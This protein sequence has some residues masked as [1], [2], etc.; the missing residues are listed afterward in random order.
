MPWASEVSTPAP[1]AAARQSPV[2]QRPASSQKANGFPRD[3]ITSSPANVVAPGIVPPPAKPWEASILDRV[4]LDQMSRMIA[5][6]LFQNVINAAPP[7]SGAEYE[8][9]AK[10][11]HLINHHTNERLRLPVLTDCIV[12]K[13]DQSMR[14]SFRSSMTESQHRAFNE[15]LNDALMKSLPPKQPVAPGAHQRIPMA[16]RH[17]RQTDAF[18]ELAGDATTGLSP[19]LLALIGNRSNKVRVR[20]TTDQKT[21]QEIAKIIKVR[22]ADLDVHSPRT[23]FDWRLSVNI[24]IKYNGPTQGLVRVMERGQPTAPRMKDRMTYNHL[25]YQ[26]DLT[27]VTMPGEGQDHSKEHELEVEICRMDEFLRQGA[28]AREGNPQNTYEQIVRGFVD[29]VRTLQRQFTVD[30]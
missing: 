27:Q 1:V 9:E 7:S 24:E 23:I 30:L 20:V 2:Q 13:D 25:A 22:I 19:S 14:T 6:F 12:N 11:G 29:N 8:V 15:F 18:Y 21:G 28:L 17:T 16:Y 3:A 10:L 26:I 4:P 5:D